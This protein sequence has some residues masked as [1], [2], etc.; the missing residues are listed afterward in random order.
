MGTRPPGLSWLRLLPG[1]VLGLRAFGEEPKPPDHAEEIAFAQRWA[2][3]ISSGDLDAAL[4]RFDWDALLDRALKDTAGGGEFERGF[5]NGFRNSQGKE[6]SLLPALLA[7]VKGGGTFTLL[8]VREKGGE[9]RALFRLVTADG[10]VNYHDC[11]LARGAD[12]SLRVTDAHIFVTGED[13][14]AT[15]RR[16]YLPF[17]TEQSKGFLARLLTAESEFVKH[18]PRIQQM[19]ELQKDGKPEEALAVYRTLPESVRREKSVL[20]LRYKAARA[21]SPEEHASAIAD[22]REAFPKE[23]CI[24]LLMVDAHLYEKRFDEALACIERVKAAVEGDAYLD[25]LGAELLLE[26]G[27]SAAAK[28]RA[29]EAIA[30]EPTLTG[31]YWFLLGISLDESD[32]AETARLLTAVERDCGIELKDLSG[33]E[34]YAGFVKSPEYRKWLERAK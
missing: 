17:A 32:F 31:A 7:V 10:G 33:V 21:V 13:L 2:R 11:L 34:A 19:S 20:L 25:L 5:R 24:D 29:K 26:K 18:W 1:L 22:F 8:R 23:T 30:A 12:G 6:G 4:A 27:D 3:E 15:V 9:L 14:S 28:R 16:A